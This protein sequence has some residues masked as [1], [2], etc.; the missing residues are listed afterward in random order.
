MQKDTMIK[1]VDVNYNYGQGKVLDQ[2]NIQI[3]QGDYV[4]IVGANGSGKSTLLKLILGLLKIQS[5]EIF[6]FGQPLAKFKD[7]EKVGFVSQKAN[8]FNSGF[9]ATVYEVVASGLTAKL[10]LFK[11]L[12]K[13]DKQLIKQTIQTV[14]ME[15][16]EQRNIGEL[17]GGQQQ[18]VF[19]ARAIVSHPTVLILDEPTVGVD[20]ENSKQFYEMLTRLNRE[21]N[22][23]LLL[24]THDLD[25]ISKEVSH[26]IQLNKRIRFSGTSG[27]F[28][29]Y[30]Q[31]EK[32]E[33]ARFE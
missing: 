3:N 28:V 14:G 10:G 23:T 16:F 8:S 22:L 25:A 21:L 26:V 17:S 24:V 27:E 11:R 6:L 1:I 19:I 18:R 20:V 32:G 9:P 29:D 15:Q 30:L 7:W 31:G 4:A 5:G 12:S 33:V 13:E 2:I